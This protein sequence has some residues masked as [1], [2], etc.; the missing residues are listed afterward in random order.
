[1]SNG[2]DMT[3][4]YKIPEKKYGGFACFEMSCWGSF[5]VKYFFFFFPLIFLLNKSNNFQIFLVFRGNIFF[6]R[7]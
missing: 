4:L 6:L 2:Q 5:E 3:R 1:M 7:N